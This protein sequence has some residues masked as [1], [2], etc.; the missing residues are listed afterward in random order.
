MRGMLTDLLLVRFRVFQL[1]EI[2]C[3]VELQNE[4][5]ALAIGFPVDQTRVGF[6]R[7]VY[8]SDGS[9]YRRLNVARSFHR[10]DNC[11]CFFGVRLP[12]HFWQLDVNHVSQFRLGVVGNAD[13]HV[14]AF[15][16]NPFV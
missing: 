15:A 16:F 11:D 8:F 2:V 5:P 13:T 3:V 14:I 1:L 4:N 7:F 6:E 12:I 9:F 10:F